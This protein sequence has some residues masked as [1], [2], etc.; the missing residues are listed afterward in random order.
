MNEKQYTV[1]NK[2]T[3]ANDIIRMARELDPDY[4][5]DGI[6]QTSVAARVLRRN[7]HTVGYN[8]D[9]NLQQS[10]SQICAIQ[11]GDVAGKED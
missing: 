5:S 6:L 4:G 8:P 1:D 11:P 10:N 2:P 3:S 7:G 9:Y